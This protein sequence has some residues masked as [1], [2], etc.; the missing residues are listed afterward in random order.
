[1][2]SIIIHDLPIIKHVSFSWYSY[3]ELETL[4]SIASIILAFVFDN[5][6]IMIK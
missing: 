4:N 3:S 2:V 6:D 1:M 5:N